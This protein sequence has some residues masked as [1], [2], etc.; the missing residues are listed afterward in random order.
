[1]SKKQVQY[2]IES[3]L[4]QNASTIR[5]EA[6]YERVKAQSYVKTPNGQRSHTVHAYSVFAN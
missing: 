1:M 4:R 6:R 2:W 3:T 5:S